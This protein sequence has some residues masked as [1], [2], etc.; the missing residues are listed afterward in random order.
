MAPHHG[1]ATANTPALAR[2]ARP[3]LV[4]SC[5]GPPSGARAKKPDPYAEVG[6]PVWGTWPHGAVMLRWTKDGLVAET[7]LTKQ[8][9]LIPRD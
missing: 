8:R 1:S 9:L 7:Y 5:N 3:K 6:A 4:V 2:W